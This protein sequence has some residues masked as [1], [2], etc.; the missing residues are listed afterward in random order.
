MQ[1]CAS[2][3]GLGLCPILMVG[4][5]II[6]RNYLITTSNPQAEGEVTEG[7]AGQGTEV[8][9]A[10]I[11]LTQL[12]LW[13]HKAVQVHFSWQI[14]LLLNFSLFLDRVGRL[15]AAP[16]PCAFCRACHEQSFLWRFLR[17]AGLSI[18]PLCSK[19]VPLQCKYGATSDGPSPAQPEPNGLCKLSRPPHASPILVAEPILLQHT[20][21]SAVVATTV[22]RKAW[23]F[24]RIY[25]RITKIEKTQNGAPD[26]AR[27]LVFSSSFLPLSPCAAVSAKDLA[28]NAYVG[29]LPATTM[30][31][32][33]ALTLTSSFSPLLRS[34]SRKILGPCFRYPTIWAAA[35]T[36]TTTEHASE[37][38]TTTLRSE[39]LHRQGEQANDRNE[40]LPPDGTTLR[41]LSIADDGP[42]NNEKKESESN[43]CGTKLE[44]G[45]GGTFKSVVSSIAEKG[46]VQLIFSFSKT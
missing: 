40:G 35:F 23:I 21:P 5:K 17:Y 9:M 7:D 11:G 28:T 3:L 34:P 20:T 8:P 32:L 18:S 41:R 33:Y 43:E 37:E 14:C 22:L 10:A 4:K 39:D 25:P 46:S 6:L 13:R 36:T 45:I 30:R 29:H 16:A 44:G 1:R 27:F 26:L 2:V 38:R 24:S 15:H 31:R 19:P 12:L 42:S